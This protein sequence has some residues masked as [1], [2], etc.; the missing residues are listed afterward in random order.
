[1]HPTLFTVPGTEITVQSYGAFVGLA[2]VLGWIL[3]LKFARDDKLPADYMG[4]A[5][6]LTVGAGLF[7]ARVL[8][9]MQHPERF[10]D[11]TS[12]VT[13]QAG[14]MSVGGGLLLG[15]GVSLAYC[16]RRGVPFWAWVDAA[17]PAFIIGVG[18]ER[19]GA[20][21]AGSDFGI[22]VDQGF[23]LA[24]QFPADSPAYMYQRRIMTGMKFPPGSSLPVHPVQLYALAMAV[25][26]FAGALWLRR[27]RTFSG[28]VALFVLGFYSI[29]R[30]AVED[31]FRVDSSPEVL[32]PV[33]LGH[34]AAFSI[35]AASVGIYLS[36]KSRAEKEGKKMRLWEGGPWTPKAE[37]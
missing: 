15:I 4:T 17:A 12:L 27:K 33:T 26:G 18:L 13:L 7:G 35:A 23:P 31:P 28:Q 19:L 8:W 20:F 14:G 9:L 21:L 36:R 3:S 1:V 25:V 5:Y 32:G 29:A 22:Y 30:M 11:W 6:V 37:K 16:A 34:M 2:L 10:E 24:V